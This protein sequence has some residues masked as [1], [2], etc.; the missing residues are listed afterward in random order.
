MLK[1]GNNAI[2]VSHCLFADNVVLFGVA[3][4]D[5]IHSVKGILDDFC[6][7]LGKKLIGRSHGL[8]LLDP[9]RWT[10]FNTFNKNLGL[11]TQV[12]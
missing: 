1:L 2:D 12:I 9:P 4:K 10:L 11:I 3:N 5:T 8:S 6:S 7:S